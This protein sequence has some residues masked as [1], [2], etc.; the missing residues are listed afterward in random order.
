[1][2]AK[3]LE[4]TDREKMQALLNGEILESHL[5]LPGNY[6]MMINYIRLNE[7]GYIV[8]GCI[9]GSRG[10]T[11]E[12]LWEQGFLFAYKSV[13]PVKTTASIK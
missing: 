10:R 9:D 6:G 8:Q 7:E 12:K 5:K 2:S 1:M 11:G 4:Q 13:K 3:D